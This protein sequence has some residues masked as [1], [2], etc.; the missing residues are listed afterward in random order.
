VQGKGLLGVAE[1]VGVPALALSHRAEAL[2]DAPLAGVVAEL[3]VQ[4]QA[5]GQV[6]AGLVVAGEPDA[7]M[8]EQA[9]GHSLSCRVP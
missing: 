8:R 6:G 2:V 5:L 4:L 9:P 1:C 3:P 7:G